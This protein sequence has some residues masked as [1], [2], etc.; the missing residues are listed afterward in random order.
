MGRGGSGRSSDGL[1]AVDERPRV[2][3]KRL[4]VTRH[5]IESILQGDSHIPGSSPS[6]NTPK[7]CPLPFR[8]PL[9]VLLSQPWF[10]LTMTPRPVSHV[11]GQKNRDWCRG[12]KTCR[13]K[14]R[15]R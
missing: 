6:G 8:Y 3:K 14:L 7:W 10:S 5:R 1:R 2:E 13:H 15:R 4:E 9:R 11:G 12:A